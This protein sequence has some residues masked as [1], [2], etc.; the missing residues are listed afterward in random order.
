MVLTLPF[1][2]GAWQSSDQAARS[3]LLLQKIIFRSLDPSGN[4]QK[5]FESAIHR[6]VSLLLQFPM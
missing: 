5:V 6:L 1:I 3:M 2:Y 4:S